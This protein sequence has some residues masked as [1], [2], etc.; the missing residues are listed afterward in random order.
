MS[1][2]EVDTVPVVPSSDSVKKL[3]DLTGRFAIVTGAGAGIGLAIADA[4]A[5]CGANVAIWYNS[6]KKAIERAEEISKK[7][8]VRCKAFQVGV[9]DEAEVAKAVEEQ[10]AEFGGKLDIMVA[11][12]GIPW[13]QGPILQGESS[14]MR[15]V[16]ET[17]F[18][19]VY[20][21]AKAAGAHFLRQHREDNKFSGS[22]IATASMSGHIVNVPQKQAVYNAAKAAVSHFCRSLAVE[23]AGFA[24]AN[25]VSPGY[26]V[27]DISDFIPPA[28]KKVWLERTP[29]R[30]EGFPNELKGAYILLASDAGSYM[31]GADIVVDGGFSCP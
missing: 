7:Y 10:V 9:T 15:N 5:E 29:M 8:N 22:F 2:F 30:R 21:T 4:F 28:Y 17:D 20:Y 31:T 19:G 1:E 27:T 25:A 11:N 3:F 14:H 18:N 12:A 23:W 26:I 6:N 24:R 16:M 13:T